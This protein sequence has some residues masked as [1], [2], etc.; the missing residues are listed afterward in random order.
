MAKPKGGKRIGAGRK[1]L[2]VEDNVREAIKKAI[3]DNP[4][5]INQIWKRVIKEAK[6]GSDKHTLLLFNYYY[7][8]P[9][10]NEGQPTEMI[11]NV[12]RNS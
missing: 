2:A 11:I 5:A 1:P 4:D 7:G 3:V 12:L 8:K 10:E 9:K 6:A